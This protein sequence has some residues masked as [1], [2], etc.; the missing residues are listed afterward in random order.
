[1]IETNKVYKMEAIELLKQLPDNSVDL[2]LTDPP[3]NM[4]ALEWDKKINLEELWK[5]LKRVG[6]ENCAFVFT[7]SQPFTSILIM[8]NLDMF[9]HEWIWEKQKPSNFMSFK[10]QPAKY[11]ENIIVFCKGKPKYNPIKWF[12]DESKRDKRKTINN[13]ITN[14]DCH[15]GSIKR[16]RKADDGSRYP[17]SILKID[18]K[19]NGNKHP[20]QKPE[21][22]M[23]YLVK[24]YS[25]E[26]DVVLDC[27]VG[28][29]TTAV[30]SKKLNRNFIC[31][32]INEE[33]IKIAE[34]RLSEIGET[35]TK[36]SNEIFPSESLISVKEEFQK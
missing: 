28:S 17:K 35:Q 15:L 31:S 34:S 27:F 8:S 16:I 30:A 3:Y 36:I 4:T 25:D 33:Y 9:K 13:P 26:N 29:G 14:K 10:F 1:M 24:T 23:E 32:D 2:V 22:L 7:A 19:I 12:V 5:E 21:E 18:K 20:T 11:H 6:K